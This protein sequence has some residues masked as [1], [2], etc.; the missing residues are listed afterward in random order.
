MLTWE[1]EWF[2]LHSP[3]G[4]YSD[5]QLAVRQRGVFYFKVTDLSPKLKQM[6]Q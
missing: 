6:L 5:K 2:Q 4:G 1:Q 3:A